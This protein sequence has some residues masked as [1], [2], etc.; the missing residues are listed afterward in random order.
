[1]LR[2]GGGVITRRLDEFATAQTFE[3][4]LDGA[5]R[6]AGFFRERTQTRR[7]RFPSLTCRL[8]VEKDI[9]EICRRLAI[10]PDDVAHQDIEDVI[11]DRNGSAKTR[12]ERK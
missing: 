5:F 11:V 8:S 2:H 6:Q 4:G 12:H 3:C 7:D 1:M 10:V 9:N